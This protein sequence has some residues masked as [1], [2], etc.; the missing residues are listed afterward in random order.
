ML[1]IR[2]PVVAALAVIVLCGM[3]SFI[4]S[5]QDQPSGNLQADTMGPQCI[6]IIHIDHTQVIDDRT[7]IFYL[8]GGEVLSN[9]LQNDCVGLHLATRGFTYLARNDEIC[10]NLQQIRVNDTRAVCQLG[11]FIREPRQP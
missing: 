5:A 7:I 3:S 6:N 9:T 8:K 2:I 1:G 11:Q 4:V 10:G